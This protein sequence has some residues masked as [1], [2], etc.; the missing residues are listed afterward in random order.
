MKILEDAVNSTAH[1]NKTRPI[2]IVSN[3]LEI[4]KHKFPYSNIEVVKWDE[5]IM[6]CLDRP[7]HKKSIY[8]KCGHRDRSDRVTKSIHHNIR[9]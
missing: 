2:W 7:E 3:N 8:V 4:H 6:D 5:S 9:I 1:F